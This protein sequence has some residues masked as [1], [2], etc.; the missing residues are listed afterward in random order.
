M[1]DFDH[2]FALDENVNPSPEAAAGSPKARVV[3]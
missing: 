3:D 1:A 2:S